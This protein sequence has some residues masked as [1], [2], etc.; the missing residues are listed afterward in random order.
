MASTEATG[1][2]SADE[3]NSLVSLSLESHPEPYPKP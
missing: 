3:I 2:T 1:G